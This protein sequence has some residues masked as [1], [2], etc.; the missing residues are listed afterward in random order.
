MRGEANGAMFSQFDA[1][2]GLQTTILSSDDVANSNRDGQNSRYLIDLDPEAV[3]GS[4]QV[5]V[6]TGGGAATATITPVYFPNGGPSI[7]T[8]RCRQFTMRLR[9]CRTWGRPGPFHQ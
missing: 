5:T 4:F 1:S 6:S 2:P 8:Q 7:R 3:S 9:H